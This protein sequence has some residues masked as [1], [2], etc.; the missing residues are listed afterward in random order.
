MLGNHFN[1]AYGDYVAPLGQACK[2]MDIDP[3]LV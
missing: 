1:F 2:F 3:I